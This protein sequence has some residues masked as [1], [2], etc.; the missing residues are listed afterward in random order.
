MPSEP[1]GKNVIL[2]V[3]FEGGLDLV[4][5]MRKLVRDVCERVGAPGGFS[6]S[7]AVAAHELLENATRYGD[8][9]TVRLELDIVA[10]APQPRA[11]I[12]VFNRASAANIE[13]LRE[14]FREVEHFADPSAHYQDRL[15]RAATR[16]DGSGLGLVRIRSEAKMA[17]ALTVTEAEIALQADSEANHV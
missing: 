17:L 10:L 1:K 6:A 4:P 14:F 3:S 5:S 12:S 16:T 13:K 2:S 7:V 11:R 15:R 9:P 8:S